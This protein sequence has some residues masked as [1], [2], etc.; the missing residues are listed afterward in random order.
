ML[1]FNK[2]P[3]NNSNNKNK[4][5][6]NYKK[7]KDG[8][9]R[10]LD[11]VKQDMINTNLKVEREKINFRNE[12]EKAEKLKNNSSLNTNISPNTRDRING[13]NNLRRGNFK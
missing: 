1:N 2:N 7:N 6:G 10:S 4:L 11:E 9:R 13:I 12:R 3:F 5:V 8:G